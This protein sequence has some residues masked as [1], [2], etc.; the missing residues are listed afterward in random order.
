MEKVDE[1]AL[2]GHAD[3]AVT[4]TRKIQEAEKRTSRRNFLVN[5]SAVATVL[6]ASNLP[7]ESIA[8]TDV[9]DQAVKVADNLPPNV[10]QW[11][12]SLGKPTATPYGAPSS[13]ETSTIR[14]MSP[15]LTEPMS[16]FSVSPL[17]ELDGS[18]TPNGVFY[19]RHHAGV[20][21]INPDEHRLII[22]GLVERP[23]V[24][25][26]EELRQFPCV[27]PI[28]FLECSGNPP[29]VPP[30]RKTAADITGLVSCAQWTGVPLKT[31]LE[32]VGLKKEAKW[33]VAEGADGAG[34]T[35]SIPIEKCLDDVLIVYSQN[36]E[37]LRPEQG[38]PIRL[39]VPGYEGNMSIKWLRR[40]Q[41][42]QEPAYSREE[43]SKYTDLM[44]DGRARKFSF[45]MDCKSIITQ[46]SGTQKLIRKGTHEIRGIA[47]SG[48]GKVK[49]VDVSVDGGNTWKEA[50]LQEPVL[51]KALV[52]FRIPFE[53]NG[54]ETVIMSRATDETG[55][56]Q[57]TLEQLL[58]VRGEWSNYHNNA[59]QPWKIS[60][61]GE[62]TN[63][64][65]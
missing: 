38:Y 13:F 54:E 26:V 50:V 61:T 51:S 3:A 18:I 40:I 63:A 17:Q 29:F 30:Y 47:W 7:T 45:V 65:L 39:F 59:I 28:Y 10:P 6:A 64:R 35:R 34:M 37:R 24:F 43:T 9:K 22:H 1:R 25:T 33:I 19:E 49:A 14:K 5:S 44:A 56:V 41:V 60:A 42:T 62:V 27:S 57:P 11:T 32:D 31:L 21:Q 4:S 23:L 46:P 8:A 48:H 16:A 58:E 55:Y 52:A 12:R 15:G 53:W 2:S 20:P 36:G